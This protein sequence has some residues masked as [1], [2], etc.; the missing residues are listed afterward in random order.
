MRRGAASGT[1]AVM[2]VVLDTS[3]LVAAVRSRLGASFQILRLIGTPAFD[4]A[5]SVPL[6]LEYESVLLRHV[7][8]SALGERE[9]HDIIDYI[10]SVAVRQ[11]VFYLWRPFLRDVAD[12]MVLELAVAAG[13]DAIITHNTRDFA[14]A[15][16]LGPRV[17]TPGRF[18]HNI[19]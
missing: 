12:D 19:R 3:I 7:A 6:V 5:V 15:E 14:G 17:L 10:C 11:E 8:S 16:Q 13:C 18:L 9:M 1:V 2:L 4:V